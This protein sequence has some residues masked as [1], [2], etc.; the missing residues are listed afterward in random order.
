VEYKTVSGD[1]FDKIAY[2]FYRNEK[3]ALNIIEANIEYANIIIFGAGV[4]LNIPDIEIA[5]TTNLP[6]WKRGSN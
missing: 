2:K 6:P 5:Q 1:T 3:Q 4:E